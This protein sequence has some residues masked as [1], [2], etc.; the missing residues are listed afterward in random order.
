MGY[1]FFIVIVEAPHGRELSP[2]AEPG[3]YSHVKKTGALVVLFRSYK[4]WFWYFLGSSAQCVVLELGLKTFQAHPTKQDLGTPKRF[5]SKYRQ[6]LPSFLH[7]S[8][9]LG[10]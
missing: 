1:P 9:P 5:F 7:G 2:G 10:S 4:K 3:G 6:A 8:S